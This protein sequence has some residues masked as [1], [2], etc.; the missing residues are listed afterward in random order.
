MVQNSSR[1]PWVDYLRGFITLLVVAHHSSLA[2]TTFASFNKAAYISSTH[3][4]VDTMRSR[5]L[6]YFE[7][8]NDIFF[9]SLMF[10]ISGVFVMRSLQNKGVVH[11]MRDRFYPLVHSFYDR[12]DG[13]DAGSLLSGV[14]GGAYGNG[15]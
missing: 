7:D 8:F 9:M 1:I 2:Y 13:A 15:W 3:P 14:A 10:L 12:G 4:I 11:F 5:G 6:D